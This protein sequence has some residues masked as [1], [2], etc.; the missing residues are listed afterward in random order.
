MNIT[1][2]ARRIRDFGVGTYI[3]NLLQALAAAGTD[4]HYHV[5][6]SPEDMRQFA[7][8]PANFETVVYPRPASSRLDPLLLP[9]LIPRLRTYVTHIPFHRVPLFLDKPYAVTI[10]DLSSLFYDEA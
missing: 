2:D 10:H 9:R 4:H 5:I 6:C 3:R 7:D 1:I 8:L